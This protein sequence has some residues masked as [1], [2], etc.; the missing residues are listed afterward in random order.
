M[1]DTIPAP[2]PDCTPWHEAPNGRSHYRFYRSA[3]GSAYV[4]LYNDGQLWST[5]IDAA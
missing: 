4:Q 3:A 2:G 1:L 5:R